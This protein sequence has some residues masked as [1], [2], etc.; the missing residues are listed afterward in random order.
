VYTAGIGPQFYIGGIDAHRSRNWTV[1]GNT[2]RNIPSPSKHV[3]E[4]AIHFLGKS[5][6]ITVINNTIEDCDRGIGF[7]LGHNPIKQTN[8]EL[9]ENNVIRST[10]LSPP[11]A[12]AGIIMEAS[13]NVQIIRNQIYIESGYPNAIE[14]RFAATK[15]YSSRII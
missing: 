15:F 13:P 8:G 5:S 10:N 1:E 11:Y 7:G 9:I 3:A 14:S 4:H 12:D 2:F 6:N